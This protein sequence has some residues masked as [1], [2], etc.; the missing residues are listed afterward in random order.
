ML[1]DCEL[2]GSE[3]RLELC[4]PD[5]E[6]AWSFYRDIMAAWVGTKCVRGLRT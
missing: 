6:Q 2:M 1:I 3:R 5:V 4:V